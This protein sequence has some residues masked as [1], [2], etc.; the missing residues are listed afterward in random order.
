MAGF[1][2]SRVDGVMFGTTNEHNI[3]IEY[4]RAD[5]AGYFYVRHHPVSHR[6]FKIYLVLVMHLFSNADLQISDRSFLCEHPPAL[7][8]NRR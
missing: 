7:V 8:L 3:S 4:N 5:G 2:K 6:T 1:E